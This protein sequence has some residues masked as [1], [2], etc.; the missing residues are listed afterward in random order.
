MMST[1]RPISAEDLYQLQ[2][3][4]ECAISP[5]GEHIIYSVQSV[6]EQKNK[7]SSNLWVCSIKDGKSNQFTVGNQIDSSPRWSPDGKKIAFLSNRDD[8]KQPQIY[9]IPFSGG[10][11]RPLTDVQG[12][13]AG[14]KWSPT[15]ED[16]ICQFRKKD[17]D[18]IERDE[19][20]LKKELGIV[21]RRVQRVFYRFDGRGFLPDERWHIWKIEG[22]TGEITQLTDGK[23]FDETFPSWAPDGRNIVFLSNHAEDPDLDPDAVDVFIHSLDQGKTRKIPT[24]V[25]PKQDPVFSPDGKWI[26][27]YGKEGRDN[28]WK[29]TSLWLVSADGKGG[30]VNLTHEFDFDLSNTI[31]NDFPGHLPLS[32]P[33]WSPDSSKIYFSVSRHG[34]VTLHSIK[35]EGGAKNMETVIDQGG[36]LG[37]VTLDE[38]QSWIAY[39]HSSIQEPPEVMVYDLKENRSQKLSHVNQ[40]ALEEILFGEVEM[41]WFKGDKGNDIQGWIMKPPFFEEGKKYPAILEIHGGPRAQY[42]DIFMHEFHYLAAQGYVVFFA[43]PRGGQG[44]GEEHSK[45][46]W[47]NW[48]TVDYE[49][50]MAW[51]E[52][53]SKLSYVDSERLG[54]TGG[55]YGGYMTNWIIGQTN[56]FQA[57]VTQRSVS[58]L[59]SM[60][61][62][63]DLN[64]AFQFE[65]G[66]Q[67]PWENLENYWRQS[68]LKHIGNAQTPTLV[69][70]S[71]NDL[72]VAIEQGEQVFVALKKLGVD[73]EMIRYPDEPHGLSRAGRTDRRIDRL[74]HIVRWFNKYLQNDESMP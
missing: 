8:K 61:G 11:A 65:F 34:K 44:Y 51:T 69:I 47:N 18:A 68:P 59:I 6:D 33:I 4:N 74:N 45:A 57:A 64:W 67:P 7:K 46:I 56:R 2:E 48:G 30:A 53:V 71:E 20:D 62:S 12:E 25:G 35:K 58:N 72:R 32:P 38:E 55:S 14:F 15:G 36:A 19:D 40:A 50:I 63:S 26:V 60:Y 39:L 66:N 1:K 41:V 17:K 49:D 70:H 22:K 43:N 13:I 3:L 16:L 5:D 31:I 28:W 73:T 37:S 10:E 52:F 42:G 54:V 24:P 21:S 27:Y 29:N 23:T 9:I